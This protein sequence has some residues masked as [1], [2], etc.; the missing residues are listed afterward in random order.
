MAF[1]TGKAIRAWIAGVIAGSLTAQIR[2]D[3][4]SRTLDVIRAAFGTLAQIQV[5]DLEDRAIAVLLTEPRAFTGTRQRDALVLVDPF[6]LYTVE[7]G[8]CGMTVILTADDTLAGPT[9]IAVSR[10]E[11]EAA[12]PVAIALAIGCT[13]CTDVLFLETVSQAGVTIVL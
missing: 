8:R 11:E 2:A 5:A 1:F 12:A 13:R 7:A 3:G 10:C 6:D 4:S 9:A